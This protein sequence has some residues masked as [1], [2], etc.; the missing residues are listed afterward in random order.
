MRLFED[1]L[2]MQEETYRFFED[3]YRRLALVE[4]ALSRWE[5][6]DD[7][8]FENEMR[9]F[10]QPFAE[11]RRIAITSTASARDN[12]PTTVD[13]Y[14]TPDDIVAEIAIPGLSPGDL[15]INVHGNRVTLQGRFS[16][17]IELPPGLDGDQLR[18][19]YRDGVL[20]LTLPKPSEPSKAIPIEFE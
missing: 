7:R 1:L 11:R 4:L 18:A 3:V 15:M 6:A 20:R 8:A 2:D 10:L 9:R 13:I 14:D 19:Q 17:T 16:R 5:V 12:H